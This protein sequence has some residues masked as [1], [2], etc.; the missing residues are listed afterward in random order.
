[1]DGRLDKIDGGSA[2]S[3][4]SYSTLADKVSAAKDRA[5][6]AYSLAYEA[7]QDTADGT[8]A[9]TQVAGVLTF[10][11]NTGDVTKNLA[12][13]MGEIRDSAAAGVASAAEAKQWINDAKAVGTILKNGQ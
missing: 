10:D 11:E 2:F 13:T 9:W 5:D 6:N 7:K 3:D 12:T 4:T 8:N 1:L